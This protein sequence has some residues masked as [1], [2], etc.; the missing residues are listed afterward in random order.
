MVAKLRDLDLSRL[1]GRVWMIRTSVDLELPVHRV[2]QCGFWQ[3]AAYSLF[4]QTNRPPLSEHRGALF[5]QPALISAVPAVN[6][7]LV[8]TSRQPY[9]R[10]VHDHDMVTRVDKG[11]ID[12]LMFALQQPRRQCGHSAEHLILCIDDV[13]PAAC[14]L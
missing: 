7:L 8:F 11:R 4:D 13:P 6:L 14:A 2:S 10:C 3:H 9:L 12:R 1:L 5:T